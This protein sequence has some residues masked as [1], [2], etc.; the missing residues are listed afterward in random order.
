MRQYKVSGMTCGGCAN[1]VTRIV[2]RLPEVERAVVDLSS[3]TLTVEGRASEEDIRRAVGQ[4]GY[5]VEERV[6]G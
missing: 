6:S 5:E 3:G 1:A 2:E 4:A